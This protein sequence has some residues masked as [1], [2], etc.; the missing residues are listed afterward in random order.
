MTLIKGLFCA[1]VLIWVYVCSL[2]FSSR[3]RH[4]RCAL[5]TGFQTSALPICVVALRSAAPS[6]SAL[7]LSHLWERVARRAGRGANSKAPSFK[8]RSDEHRV[9]TECVGTCRSRWSPYHS[10]KN[11]Q[12]HSSSTVPLLFIHNLNMLFHL[13]LFIF[14]SSY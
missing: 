11:R 12:P 6:S 1:L 3:R 5:V 8:I 10:K 2:F 13:T 14:T 4:T 7:P 9:G